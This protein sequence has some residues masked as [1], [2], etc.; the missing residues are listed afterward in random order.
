[1]FSSGSFVQSAERL[2]YRNSTKHIKGKF[3]N[4]KLAKADFRYS[5]IAHADF[6]RA[7]LNN[8][9]FRNAVASHASFRGANC[10]GTNFSHC[11]LSEA[12][13]S[14]ADLR[15]AN[16]PTAL[17]GRKFT[18]QTLYDNRTRFPRSFDPAKLGLTYSTFDHET[19]AEAALRNAIKELKR[20][21]KEFPKTIAAQRA[22]KLLEQLEKIVAAEQ[23]HLN[24][25]RHLEAAARGLGPG[26]YQK[27]YIK[28]LALTDQQVE[29]LNEIWWEYKRAQI[30]LM[31]YQRQHNRPP[32]IPSDLAHN[33]RKS[34]FL[35][36]RAGTSAWHKER[37]NRR[38]SLERRVGSRML[39]VL[40][41][42]Q[43]NRW[44]EIWTQ[45]MRMRALTTPFIQQELRLTDHQKRTMREILSD[46]LKAVMGGRKTST[47]QEERKR[48][49]II[50]VTELARALKALT[51]S[52]RAKFLAMRG[53]PF[54]IK[55]YPKEAGRD[56]DAK[57]IAEYDRFVVSIRG[58]R[59]GYDKDSN[60]Y[61]VTCPGGGSVFV[62]DLSSERLEKLFGKR[63]RF[64]GMVHK[65]KLNRAKAYA[66]YPS[67]IG[68]ERPSDKEFSFKIY[69]YNR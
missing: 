64:S 15:G 16:L 20:I 29:Q 44:S 28:E 60:S 36:N 27:Q 40:N 42:K 9:D 4:K 26:T 66:I 8:A 33:E 10:R 25:Q 48:D 37:R 56:G 43:A 3:S 22:S 59:I 41:N 38:T 65:V 63:V 58:G 54:K 24:R 1:M 12:D 52:Q 35:A 2:D 19:V 62:L 5:V 45:L 31:R 17:L 6:S 34:R 69:G 50:L 55:R 21:A 7:N 14:G 61:F 67:R 68:V 49:E 18:K 32:P 23:L 39:R 51:P 30:H 47:P 53:K 13:F 46:Y 57:R 11:V